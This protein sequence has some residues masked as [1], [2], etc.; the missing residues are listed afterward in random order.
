MIPHQNVEDLMLKQEVVEAVRAG[1]FHI[2][3]VRTIDEGIEILT[4]VP[5]GQP[6]AQGRYPEG[7]VHYRVDQRLRELASGLKAFLSEES[8]KP[9]T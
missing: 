4:G 1:R 8:E 9:G 3:P 7:S 2:Y 6:D 5:A